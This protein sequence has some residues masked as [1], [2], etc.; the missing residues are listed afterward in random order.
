MHHRMDTADADRIH[1]H[2]PVF[3]LQIS[4]AI[5]AFTNWKFKLPFYS[6]ADR[7][8]CI[9]QRLPSHSG[10]CPDTIFTLM[11]RQL[12]WKTRKSK[13]WQSHL[14]TNCFLLSC[15]ISVKNSRLM[16]FNLIGR[17]HGVKIVT[18]V[19][20]NKKC[21]YIMKTLSCKLRTLFYCFVIRI[22]GYASSNYLKIYAD[23]FGCM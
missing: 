7:M 9:I 11:F 17:K 23:N 1:V 8:L 14:V 16:L 5:M 6:L 19:H 2:A 13:I 18:T 20:C 10:M 22:C 12:N 3:V 21:N 4:V 15:R